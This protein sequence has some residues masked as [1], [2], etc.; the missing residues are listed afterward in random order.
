M[1]P[2]SKNARMEVAT[3]PILQVIV[4]TTFTDKQ[5]D[6]LT[7]TFYSTMG[8]NR[9]HFKYIHLEHIV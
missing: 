6:R 9:K 4:L 2:H 8:D 1:Q 7:P 5:T 3:S